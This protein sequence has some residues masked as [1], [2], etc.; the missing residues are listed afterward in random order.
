MHMI[1]NENSL[2]S[3]R[4]SQAGAYVLIIL[5]LALESCFFFL[6][7]VPDGIYRLCNYH[8]KYLTSLLALVGMFGLLCSRHI[9]ARR[10][11]FAM[12]LAAFVLMCFV[13]VLASTIHYNESL[14]SV[15]QVAF[16]CL[17]IPLLYFSLHETVVNQSMY[18]FL[19]NATIIFAFV[20]AAI[21]LL[22]S[23]GLPLMKN[24]I[25]GVDVVSSR[26]G[27]DRI[28]WTGD[29]VAFGAVLALGRA[30]STRRYRALSITAFSV[31][32]FELFWVAQTR[33]LLIALVFTATFG[34]V[35]KGK[36]RTMK[37]VFVVVAAVLIAVLFSDDLMAALFPSELDLS[38]DLRL[39]A[40]PYYWSHSL[41]MGL[42]GLGY[43]PD[44]SLHSYLLSMVYAAGSLRGA[45][46]D[47]GIVGY[48]ARYG[49]CGAVVLAL[50]IGCLVKGYHD[51]NKS[52]FSVGRNVEA[53]MALA[54]FIATSPTMAITDP[55]RLFYLPVLAL[56]LEH[57][58]TCRPI[59]SS[60]S[61][62]L[63]DRQ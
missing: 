38:S 6:S 13:L 27:R 2:L 62:D 47:I 12:P 49:V 1:N 32:V 31:M 18:K 26:N 45:I 43:I 60:A 44:G 37:I 21:A 50:S 54:F 14:L 53:W 20:F 51:R 22:Q 52:T 46:T 33:F 56:L 29:F 59:Q 8:I 42:F 7:I 35:I 16:P 23:L 30:Y 10:Y 5:V 3:M 15:I 55:Q 28:I 48:I 34:F 40:Y 63:A 11:M 39:G 4:V 19:I 17:C 61:K 58:L 36:S 41:D 24:D 25:N 57:A 9:G